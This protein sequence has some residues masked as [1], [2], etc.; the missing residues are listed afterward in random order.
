TSRDRSTF[1]D[2][3]VY[4][5]G[6]VKQFAVVEPKLD[7]PLCRLGA[8]GPVAQIPAH[9]GGEV[10]PDGAGRRLAAVG[11]SQQVAGDADGLPARP[12]HGHHGGGSDELEQGW[13]EGLVNV[14]CVVA[15]GQVF[16]H[17]LHLHGFQTQAFGFQAADDGAHQA[18][19]HGVGFDHD[20]RAL[21]G[22]W[23]ASAA[24]VYPRT[25]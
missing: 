2:P 3:T 14:G 19:V 7:F 20:E 8:V 18:A 21:P 23:D 22:Q 11:G 12:D 25:C 10:V 15:A 4:V 5:P 1:D 17:P 16:Y 13:E 6:V 9:V 24:E